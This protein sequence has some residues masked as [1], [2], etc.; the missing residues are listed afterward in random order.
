MF[1]SLHTRFSISLTR[2]SSGAS[3][4]IGATVSFTRPMPLQIINAATISSYLKT[5][6]SMPPADKAL[7]IA[8][9]LNVSI[10]FLVNGFESVSENVNL[11]IKNISAETYKLALDLSE[12]END[13][14]NAVKNIV[15]VM[16][17]KEKLTEHI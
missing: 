11:M 5:K 2:S 14:L 4:R 8:Q 16:K 6:G 17:K 7:K 15:N 9:T 13:E 1:S 3:P 10:D 12:L